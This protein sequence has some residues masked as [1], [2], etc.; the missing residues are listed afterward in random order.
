[1][2]SDFRPRESFQFFLQESVELLQT[3]EQGLLEVRENKSTQSVHNLMRIVHSIKGGAACVGLNHVKKIAHNLENV[4]K[5][6]YEI[7]IE[8]DLE[9]EE[10]LLQAYDRLKSPL[11]DEIHYGGS[12]PQEAIANAKGVWTVSYTH[13]TLPTIYSV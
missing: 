11:M 7:D 9:L 1:M 6:L 2:V 3:L 12:D 10:L 4:L 5:T 8:I 13:L